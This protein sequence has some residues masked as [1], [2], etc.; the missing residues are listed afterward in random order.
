VTSG[1]C[2][3][4]LATLTTGMYP[5]QHTFEPVE[6]P[7][8]PPEEHYWRSR[9]KRIQYF[10]QAATLPRI[11]GQHGYVS[12]QAGK[13]WE[14]SYEDGGF[15]HGMTH[16]DRARGGR[17]GDEGLRIGRETMQPVFDFID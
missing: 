1:L 12:F 11:L 10:R 5:H 13:W 17:H 3:P 6:R 14:G 8:V 15:T 2:L 7:I 4:S 16:G 9:E